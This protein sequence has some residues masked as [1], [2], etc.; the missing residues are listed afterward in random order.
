MKNNIEQF[1]D[2][3]LENKEVSNGVTFFEM[4]NLNGCK[5]SCTDHD[6]ERGLNNC[7]SYA[8]DLEKQISKNWSKFLYEYC[9]F[10]LKGIKFNEELYSDLDF[11]SWHFS[12]SKKRIVYDGK[13]FDLS[14]QKKRIFSNWREIRIVK[15]SEIK[16]ENLKEF[17]DFIK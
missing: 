14:I 4:T 6:Y 5:V 2:W 11:G 1:K 16:L 17:I 12:L 15:I 9:K 13:N 3:T 8:F 7:I 10:E